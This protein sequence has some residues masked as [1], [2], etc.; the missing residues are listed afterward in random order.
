MENPLETITNQIKKLKDRHIFFFVNTDTNQKISKGYAGKYASQN[1]WTY[2]DIVKKHESVTGFFK[3]QKNEGVPG[4][5]IMFYKKHGNRYLKTEI[6]DVTCHLNVK[7]PTQTQ[8]TTVSEPQTQNHNMAQPPQSAPQNISLAGAGQN[9]SLG[10]TQLMDYER[11]STRLELIE[12]EKKRLE[13]ENLNLKND[14]SA[15]Q[16]KLDEATSKCTLADERL[17]LEK[18]KLT[19]GAKSSFENLMHTP[20]AIAFAEKFPELLKDVLASKNPQASLGSPAENPFE[21]LTQAQEQLLKLLISAKLSDE[22]A[23][24]IYTLTAAL[25]QN[26]SL[27]V[28]FN[29]FINNQQTA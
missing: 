22:M 17:S 6:P 25:Q 18:E 14:K 27:M 21:G 3:H 1:V 19:T 16:I 4:V 24:N 23:E 11:K 7:Q 5:I 13:E 8:T 15:L 29:Q 2:E 26:P 28:S 12:A 20:A 10:F 9:V